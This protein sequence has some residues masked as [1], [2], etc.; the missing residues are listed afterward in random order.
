M[1]LFS[2]VILVMVV[3][4]FSCSQWR[5]SEL[6]SKKLF[7]IKAG[8]DV[9]QASIVFGSGDLLDISFTVHSGRDKIFFADNRL[10]RL[11]VFDN[12]GNVLCVIAGKKIDSIP[13]ST[14]FN[15]GVIGEVVSDSE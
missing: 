2:H 15:F 5:V 1:K 10:K 14:T 12:E 4:L 9:K 11:Q 3:F 8:A 7:T 13:F 6:K